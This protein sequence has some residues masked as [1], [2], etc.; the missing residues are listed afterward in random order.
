MSRKLALE[1]IAVETGLG[2]AY[3]EDDDTFNILN[4]E[5]SAFESYLILFNSVLIDI[6]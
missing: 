1:E 6:H 5:Q 4:E 3:N 2:P